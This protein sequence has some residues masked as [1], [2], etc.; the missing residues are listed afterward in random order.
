[1]LVEQVFVVLPEKLRI[2]LHKKAL[3]ADDCTF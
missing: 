2:P 1:M 3:R